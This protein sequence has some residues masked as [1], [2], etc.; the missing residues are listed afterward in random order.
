MACKGICV[1]HKADHEG[2]YTLSYVE[3]QKRCQVCPIYLIWQ[4]NNY[5]PCCRNKFRIKPCESEL[6]RRYDEIIRQSKGQI[7]TAIT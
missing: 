6:K 2:G 3:G 4:T 7:T 1:R 5:C